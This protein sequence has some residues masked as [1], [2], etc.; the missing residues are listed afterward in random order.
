MPGL[1]DA[2]LHPSQD[3][4]QAD[5]EAL[6]TYRDPDLPGW[7]RRAFSPEHL[8]ARRWLRERMEQA[9]LATSIDAAGN[10]IGRREGRRDLD[11]IM[12]GSHIDTIAGGERFDGSVGVLAGVEIA[13]C[14]QETGQ[15]LEHPLEV[16]NFVAQEALTSGVEGVGARSLN[17]WT[18]PSD[19]SRH[20]TGNLTVAECIALAGGRPN[21]HREAV[22]A[23]ASVTAYLELHVEQG[24][25]LTSEAM[26]VG[27]VTQLPRF[28]RLRATLSRRDDDSAT[29]SVDIH[30]RIV[31]ALSEIAA[32]VRRLEIDSD[33]E[34]TV[35]RLLVDPNGPDVVMGRVELW[36]EILNAG[37]RGFERTWAFERQLEDAAGRHDLK[38]TIASTAIAPG[39]RLSESVQGIFEQTIRD[40]GLPV[41]RL[42]STTTHAASWFG[43]IGPSGML[44]IPSREGISHTPNEWTDAADCMVGIAVLGDAVLRIDERV[45]AGERFWR[46][47]EWRVLD[48]DRN[49]LGTLMVVGADQPWWF[50][51]FEAEPAFDAV[52][53]RFEESI[54]LLGSNSTVPGDTP[55]A[56]IERAYQPIWSLGLR[57]EATHSEEY[58][59]RPMLQIRGRR[60]RL[61]GLATNWREVRQARAE[62]TGG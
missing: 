20:G 2:R 14:L 52:R 1:T 4:L 53:H 40:L 44:F 12:I 13:R 24:S 47:R 33:C 6:S 41:R 8:A 56:G 29:T 16:V 62:S 38:S 11:P 23:L 43:D 27:I 48:H 60:A 7:T 36:V 50:C 34:S 15:M 45:A 42:P 25:V 49:W 22:R 28:S 32:S 57:L 31:A 58:Y 19:L 46:G 30:D 61:R 9:S 54:R 59:E 17:Y 35:A 3:R 51:N 10:L 39:I 18:N 5:L 26:S 37:E 21:E 55:W